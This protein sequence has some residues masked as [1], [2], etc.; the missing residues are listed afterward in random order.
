MTLVVVT[1]QTVKTLADVY[2]SSEHWSR[3]QFRVQYRVH[4]ELGTV[5]S[6]LQYN[7]TLA[8]LVAYLYSS[9]SIV[10][11]DPCCRIFNYIAG[12][13]VD[14]NYFLI[15]EKFEQGLSRCALRNCGKSIEW[16]LIVNGIYIEV[17]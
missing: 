12:K 7:C 1:V 2:P 10:L 13:R 9:V 8:L 3:V 14:L 4:T 15:K 11:S 16:I 6:T 17:E 5:Y